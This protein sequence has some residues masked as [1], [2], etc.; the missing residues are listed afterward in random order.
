MEYMHFHEGETYMNILKTLSHLFEGRLEQKQFIVLAILMF[1]VNI[2]AIS[3]GTSLVVALGMIG[4]IVNDVVMFFVFIF[5]INLYVRRLHDIGLTGLIV[6][7]VIVLT[8][9]S[10]LFGLTLFLWLAIARGAVFKNHYG[11]IPSPHRSYVSAFLN[12]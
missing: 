6:V 1:L 12:N 3:I 2:L 9:L 4:L 7:P 11:G 5:T 8:L 10:Q